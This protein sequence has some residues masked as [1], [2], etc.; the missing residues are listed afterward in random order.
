[1]LMAVRHRPPATHS[2]EHSLNKHKEIH[3]A[4]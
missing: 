1:M 3:L 4:T 2:I